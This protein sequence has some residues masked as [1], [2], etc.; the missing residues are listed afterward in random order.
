MPKKSKALSYVHIG[1]FT[2]NPRRLIKFYKSAFGFK[3]EKVGL[4]PGKI[5]KQIFRVSCDW[6][7]VVLALDDIRIEIF[8]ADS[9][10][11]KKKAKET[12]DIIQKDALTGTSRPYLYL[13]GKGLIQED[14]PYLF[15]LGKGL[16]HWGY[17]VKD[18]H[19]F[20]KQLERRGVKVKKVK[21]G[22]RFVYFVNDPDGNLIELMEPPKV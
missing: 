7:M 6:H 9:L 10:K 21:R 16:N 13:L 18:K 1:M 19:K 20:V 11:F 3:Q 8:Y 2:N 5:T 22:E 17:F 14:R 15:H 4:L 12:I